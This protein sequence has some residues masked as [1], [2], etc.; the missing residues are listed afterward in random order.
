MRFYDV[1]EGS[2]RIDGEDVRSIERDRLHS[3][4]GVA[5]QNDFLFSAN[6]LENVDFLRDIPK[7]DIDE[8]M[9]AS[10]ALSIIETDGY[11]REVA[12]RGQNLSGGQKQRLYIARAL[13]GEPDVLILDDSSSALDYATDLKLRSAI[14]SQYGDVTKIIVAQRISSVMNSDL[15]I[16]LKEGKIIGMGTHEQLMEDCIDYREI[17]DVQLGG[18]EIYG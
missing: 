1:D 7:V 6:V 5:M 17:A 8:A 3:I 15:I 10:Q 2:I 16:M 12:S 4:F 14:D 13:S 11:D 9:R 18:G